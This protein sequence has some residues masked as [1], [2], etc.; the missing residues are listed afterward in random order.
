MP[1]RLAD[2][3][4]FRVLTMLD[5]GTRESPALVV[6][7]SLTA[8]HV[9]VALDAFAGTRGLPQIIAVDN[10]TEFTSHALDIWAE[11][12]GIHLDFGRP[13]KP[14]DDAFIESFNSRRREECLNEEWFTSRADAQVK[15]AR[16]RLEDHAEHSHSSLGGLTPAE[17]AARFTPSA[18]ADFTR[19]SA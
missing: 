9:I 7:R 15:I 10:G 3:R 18:S 4:S 11:Q 2:G 16:F 5:E 1:D 12:R 19:L 8:R 17:Y 13:G 14:S 6:G